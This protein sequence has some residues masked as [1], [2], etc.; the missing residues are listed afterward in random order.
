[1]CVLKKKGAS[2]EV[3]G[4][5]HDG[6]DM[7]DESAPPL[8]KGLIL[9]K[10]IYY[11]R[12]ARGNVDVVHGEVLPAYVERVRE[13]SSTTTATTTSTGGD[14]DDD[15]D[16]ADVDVAYRLDICLRSFG[17]AAKAQELSDL[18][19]QRLQQQ[20]RRGNSNYGRLELGDKSTPDEIRREF[21]GISKKTF[22][23]A[24]SKLY[25]L[26]LVQKPQPY[27]ISLISTSSTTTPPRAPEPKEE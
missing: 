15:V 24:L 8:A 16:V 13:I 17:G 12:Q 5:G 21:P 7:M 25:K 18:I 11:F 2:V 6:N 20:D 14:D 4:K 10:E 19:L 3:I 22:K 26:G 1:M 23:T 9:Q 27:S